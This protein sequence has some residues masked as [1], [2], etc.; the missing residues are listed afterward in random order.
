MYRG[1]NRKQRNYF[2]TIISMY[3]IECIKIAFVIMIVPFLN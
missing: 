1:T 2:R 3:D